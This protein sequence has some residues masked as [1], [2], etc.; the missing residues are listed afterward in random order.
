MD[1]EENEIGMI[2]KNMSSWP[3]RKTFEYEVKTWGEGELKMQDLDV[4]M[5]EFMN[6]SSLIQRELENL[7][8]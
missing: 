1:E 5:H 3:V 7:W 8:Y 2:E 6:E 4:K